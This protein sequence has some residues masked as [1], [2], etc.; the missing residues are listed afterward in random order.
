MVDEFMQ[1]MKHH[2]PSACIQ[3]EDFSSDVASTI[4]ETYRN[5]FLCFNDDIQVSWLR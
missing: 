2:F 5:D 4:L 1:A 3:F